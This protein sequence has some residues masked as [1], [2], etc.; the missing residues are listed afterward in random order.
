MRM[1]LFAISNFMHILTSTIFMCISKMLLLNV[2]HAHTHCQVNT[3]AQL[4]PSFLLRTLMDAPCINE[5]LYSL[6]AISFK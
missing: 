5:A 2:I 1:F 3:N 4:M 6:S